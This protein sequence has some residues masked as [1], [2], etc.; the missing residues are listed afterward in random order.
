MVLQHWGFLIGAWA[1]PARS[2][3]QAAQTVRAYAILIATALAGHFP[4]TLALAPL[5]ACLAGGCRINSRATAPNTYQLVRDPPEI[6]LDL[7]EV[8]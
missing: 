1:C 5:Q 7:R 4:L 6:A 8:A 3:V 2:L